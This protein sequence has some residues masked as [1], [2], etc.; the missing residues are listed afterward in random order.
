MG[1]TPIELGS[2]IG[3]SIRVPAH[4]S[5]VA[6]H[7][8]S[9]GIVP[10]HGQIPASPARCRRPTWPSPGR[11]PAAVERPRTRPRRH[12]RAGSVGL[13][14]MAARPPAEPG[15]RPGRLPDR[16]LDRRRRLPGRQRHA[17]GARLGGRRDRG[18]R[19]SGRH[20]GPSRVHAGQGVRGVR[21][22]ALRR[23]LRRPS[24]GQD[25]TSRGGHQRH[26]ARLGQAGHGGTPPRL[27]LKPRAATPDPR[28][29]GGVLHRIRRDPAPGAPAR[30]D[31]ARPQRAPM[32]PDGSTSAASTGRTSTCSL[33]RAGRRRLPPGDGRAG[34]A[35]RRRP[36]DRRADR[37]ARTSTTG[38]RCGWRTSSANSAAAALGPP[39]PATDE[40]CR[41]PD[42]HFRPIWADLQGAV[43]AGRI[44]P[45][46]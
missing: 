27:A 24:E 25:R 10:A 18:R 6:G 40:S 30:R 23:A 34:R 46:P 15:D 35:R 21:R 39:S 1:F 5:G 20:R 45:G 19:R 7:K 17:A 31:P 33:D 36:A 13:P 16:G 44:R 22:P 43:R 37:R 29:V 9:F 14:R 28:A 2:D 11:W 42:R 32:G 8:P 4:Y 12:R 26:G 3:G 41:D 38:R